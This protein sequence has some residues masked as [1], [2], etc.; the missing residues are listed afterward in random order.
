VDDGFDAGC[1]EMIA[2]RV[3]IRGRRDDDEFGAGQ[4]LGRVGGGLQVQRL[5]GQPAG[6]F[7]IL[8]G[9]AAVIDLSDALGADVEGADLIVL[10]QQNGD[11]HADIA[12]A[13]NCDCHVTP[14]GSLRLRPA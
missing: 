5:F 4:R 11:G 8:D 9:R 12:Q 13:C 10:G 14:A 2:S 6:D 1:V 3:V 7:G